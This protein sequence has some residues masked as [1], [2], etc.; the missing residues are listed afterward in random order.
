MP[1]TL[2]LALLLLLAAGSR[3]QE[4]THGPILGRP[5]PTS[6]SV[7]ARTN[8]AGEF[9][10]RYGTAAGKLDQLSRPART[11]VEHDLTGAVRL[12]GL[13]PRTVYHYRVVT[14]TGKGEKAG[15]GGTF[16]TLPGAEAYRDAKHNPKGLFNFA[17]EYA[18]CNNQA[19]GD[20]AGPGLPAFKTMLAKLRG[21]VDFA[22]QNGDWL[23]EEEREYSPEQWLKQVG[24]AKKDTPD[25]VAKAPTVVGV[26]ENYKKYLTRGK[27]LAAWHAN[28]PSYFTLDD[29][30][31]LNDIW[32]AGEAGFRD[33][34]A[35]FRDIG[36]WAWQDYLGWSNPTSFTQGAHFGRGKF[37]KGSDVL[38]DDAADF[39][40]LK[41]EEMANLHVHW[42]TKTAG[43]NDN[44]LDGVGGG[45]NAGTYH[46]VKVLDKHR[47]R[48]KPAAKA[49]GV[50]SYSIGR[51][52]YYS[53]EVGNAAFF[54][55]DT[56]SH[57]RMH[58]GKKPDKK[59]VS[60]IG[61][62]QKKW[63]L[64]GIKAT[65]ADFIFVVS[66]V[67]FM[68]RHVGGGAIRE[69]DKDEAWTVFLEEREQLIKAFEALNKPVF[70]LTGDLHNCFAVKITDN[71]WEFASSP[72]NSQNHILA[73][74]DERPINGKYTWGGRTCDIRWSSAFLNDIPRK[75]L[76]QP[77]YC[78]VQ[79]NNVFRND[80]EPGKPRWVA[81][82]RPHV[83]FRYYDG[84]TG[85]LLYAEAVHAAR[86]EK[87][88]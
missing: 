64:E 56:R 70:L 39:T 36:V 87:K 66:S 85:K 16:R 78:V 81:Y 47:L 83:V 75:M 52:T 19:P 38:V 7:W 82:P 22:I 68:I 86:P 13:K 10:V 49:D 57:R 59:G 54:C 42:G 24:I 60:M 53:F 27:N 65:K 6:M 84:R 23:Y 74:E 67:T 34:R 76:A 29:H 20:G 45:P 32:G 79:V 63:L 58:D 72:H 30:E 21:E 48:V 62:R 40:K 9:R 17:F 26:W 46:I 80:K 5:G 1:R 69:G 31:I 8:R 35:V 41:L 12:T 51:R 61:P 55:L 77:F 3:G 15:P 73:D 14:G 50:Q 4:I 11:T 18:S 28:V 37:K 44:K 33:R 25:I 43:V 88:R 2:S 71:I